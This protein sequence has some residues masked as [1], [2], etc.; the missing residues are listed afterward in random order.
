MRARLISAASGA[1]ALLGLAGC[2]DPRPP[3]AELEPRAAVASDLSATAAVARHAG[4]RVDLA[5]QVHHARGLI[6]QSD[7]TY[8]TVCVDAPEALRPA[9]PRRHGQPR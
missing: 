9:P 8:K 6:R 7:G 2:G 3:A 5:G 1:L 4:L